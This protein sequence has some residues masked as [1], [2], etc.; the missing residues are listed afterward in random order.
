MVLGKRT[1]AAKNVFQVGQC[2]GVVGGRHCDVNAVNGVLSEEVFVAGRLGV[3][4]APEA[5]AGYQEPGQA[6]RRWTRGS[7]TATPGIAL[8]VAPVPSR[9]GLVQVRCLRQHPEIRWT[10]SP[11]LG[12]ESPSGWR[13]CGSFSG[14]IGVN[15]LPWTAGGTSFR[16]RSRQG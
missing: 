14:R 15:A 7:A 6:D 2:R 5:Q 9:T 11:W 16:R 1:A 4:L 12:Q 3:F 13:P 10:P 8:P